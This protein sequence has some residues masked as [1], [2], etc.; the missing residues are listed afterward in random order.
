MILFLGLFQPGLSV[1]D[2]KQ[3]TQ[4]SYVLNQF[5]VSFIKGQSIA[6]L[7]LIVKTRERK[8]ANFLG[9]LNLFFQDII[10][11]AKRKESPVEKLKRML[12]TLEK[13]GVINYQKISGSAI[14]PEETYLFVT[15]G[16]VSVEE[17]VTMFNNLP[18]VEYAEPNYLYGTLQY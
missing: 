12:A 10:A 11:R 16:R 7:Q 1:L 17:A 14:S 9:R 13:A 8:S 15:D 3:G 5:L 4:T 2:S 6:D 18:E